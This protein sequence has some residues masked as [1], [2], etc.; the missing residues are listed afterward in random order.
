MPSPNPRLAGSPRAL[1]RVLVFLLAL[2]AGSQEV[3]PVLPERSL[4]ASAQEQENE[5]ERLSPL[6]VDPKLVGKKVVVYCRDGRAYQGK[7]LE[8]TPTSLRLGIDNRVQELAYNEVGAVQRKQQNIW[9]TIFI[10]NVVGGAI[11]TLVIVLALV[12]GEG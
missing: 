7:L 11:A 1:A 6:R 8:L 4:D 10:L 12:G 5:A 3:T 2:P 9:K